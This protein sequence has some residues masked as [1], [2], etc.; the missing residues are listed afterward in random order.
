MNVANLKDIYELSH[1][2]QGLLFHTIY[3]PQ[4]GV[5]FEQFSWTLQGELNVLAFKQAWKQVVDRHPILRTGFFWQ[6]L[7]KP[8]Q[9]VYEDVQ[10][11]W[12]EQDLQEF[13]SQEQ[14]KQL[15]AFLQTDRQR[16]FELSQAPLIRLNLFRLSEDTYQFVW[17][18]HHLLLDGW[19][20]SLVFKEVYAFYAAFCQGQNLYLE[21]PRPYRDYITW[22]QQQDLKQAEAFWRKTLKGF[23]KP[24]ILQVDRA[25]GI[26]PSQDE[27]YDRQ[28]IELST[29]TTAALQSL[30]RQQQLTINTLVQGAWALLLSRYSGESDIIFGSTSSGRPATLPGVESMVGLFVNTLPFRVQILPDALLLPWLLELQ[31]HQIE[32]IQYEY[33]PLV[34]VQ[35]WSQVSRGLPL[36]EIGYVLENYP[37]DAAIALGVDSLKVQSSQSFEKTNETLSLLVVP[38]QAL[39]LELWYD[40]RRFEHEA[41]A[42]M[43]GHLQT[44]LTGIITHPTAR[45]AELPMLTP[46]EQHQ[47]L[48]EFNQNSS[49]EN[50]KSETGQCIHQL[51]EQQAI[52]TPDAIAVVFADL[53]L[54]YAQLLEKVNKLAVY[55]QTL[56]VAPGTLVGICIERS[57][58]MIIA[59]LAV[60]KAGGAYLPLDSAYPQ[61]RLAFMLEDAQVQV[62]LTQEKLLNSLP[63]HSARVLCLDTDWET[64]P[65]LNLVHFETWSSAGILPATTRWEQDAPTTFKNYG[66]QN[67]CGLNQISQPKPSDLAYVIYTSGSTGK[68]KG[69]K[70]QHSSLVNAYLAWEDAYQLR[71]SASCHLQMASFAFDVFAGDL[72]RALCSGGKLVLCPRELLLEPQKLYA[73]MLQEKVDCAEFVPAVLRNLVQYLEQSGQ[74]L[75]FMRLLIC[76]S[77]S[78]YGSEYSKFR[79]FCG[80]QTRLINSFGLTE[81]TIDSSYFETIGD[82]ASDRLVPI[83]RP[84]ANTQF[85]ILDSHLQPVP[86]GVPG[87][88]YIGGAGLAQGYFNRPDLTAQRFIFNPFE[89][90]AGSRLYKTGDLTCWLPDGN[91]EFLGRIDYQEKIRG[92]RVELGEIEATLNQHP[93]VQAVAV[94]AQADAFDQKRLVSYVVQNTQYQGT[95]EQSEKSQWETEQISQWQIVYDSEADSYQRIS[96]NQNP[97]FN[98][99]GWNSSYTDLPIPAEEM[100]IWLNNTV[101]RILSLKPNRVLEIGCGTGLIL[102]RIAPVCTQYQGT[103]FSQATLHYIQ[104]VLEIPEYHLSQV[105][106]SQRMA[107]NFAGLSAATYDTIIINSVIQYFPSIDYLLRAIAGAVELVKPGGAIFVG[108]VRSLPLLEAFHTAVI[109]HSASDSLSTAQVQQQVQKRLAQEEELVIDPAFFLALSQYLPQITN[110]EILPKQGRYNNEL[111]KF[112]YDVILHVGSRVST[113]KNVTWLDWQQQSLTLNALIELLESTQP[114]IL[115][116][117]RIPNARLVTEVKSLELL[118]LE[119]AYT[120]VGEL[121]SVLRAIA[122]NMGVEPEDFWTLSEI[123]PYSVDISWS[124]AHADG[125][126]DVLLQRKQSIS[127]EM[128]DPSPNLSPKRREALIPPSLQGKGGRGVRSA[129]EFKVSKSF[130]EMSILKQLDSPRPWQTYANNPLQGKVARELVPQLRHYLQSKLPEYMVPSAFVLLD[131]LPLTPNGKIDRLALPALETIRADEPAAKDVTARTPIQEMLIGIWTQVLGVN[132]I[133]ISDNFFELGGHSLLATQ[134]ISRVREAFQIELPLRCL[135]ESPTIAS[136][137][138]DIDKEIKTQQGLQTPTFLSVSRDEKLPLSFAQQRLWFLCQLAPDKSIYNDAEAL[139]VTGDL[140]IAALE[141]SINEIVRRHE[142]LRMTFPVILGEPTIAIAPTLTINLPVIDLRGIDE[143]QREVKA[144]Q[145]ATEEAKSPFDLTQS[146]L[147]RTTLLWLDQ[148]EY[149][150]LLSLHHIVSDG[151]SMGVWLEELA[152]LYTAF[153]AGK[154]SPLPQLPIQYV[155]F[156]VW[157]RQWLQGE[158]LQKQLTYWQNQ[159]GQNLPPLQLPIDRSRPAQQSYQAR[160]EN[161]L[162][163]LDLT[164]QLQLLSQEEGVTLFMTL[165][166]AFKTLLYCYS[167]QVDIRVG[168]P[169]ANRNRAEIEKLIGF[170]VNTLVLRTDLSKNPSFCELLRRVREVTL[171]AY[172][173]QDLPFEKIVEQLRPERQ[174]NHLPLFQ[175]WFVLQNAPLGTLELPS[176]TLQ[177]LDIHNGTSEYDLGL[178]LVETPEGI[179]GCFEYSTDLFF[180]DTITRM[181][182]HWQELLKEIVT[183]ADLKIDAIAANFAQAERVHKTVKAQEIEVA[184]IQMLKNIKRQSAHRS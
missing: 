107:D 96:L 28:Q 177:S 88:L 101:E 3:A 178:F 5:Y 106:L 133:G 126:Y 137:S 117:C 184:N 24:T 110:V 59:P 33:S 80:S 44:L 134:V 148:T 93:A 109:L 37:V 157:Q 112:R 89:K 174:Q 136:L 116:L 9:V 48:V 73:L 103:D 1:I 90:T 54:T 97:A 120:T 142:T 176:L 159:L 83:G 169:I 21:Q 123:L 31:N 79:S 34:Q 46:A 60:L 27:D 168:S 32:I 113:P 30:A 81:A 91:V 63:L 61:E 19:S 69:V 151:W 17:S 183:T 102:F 124:A 99:T 111:S 130:P 14:Q 35:G 47:L 118:K 40:T 170:F 92:Y 45:L 175:V 167:R 182:A 84:F 6:D 132:K 160:V 85:Y 127:T 145:I 75:D 57:L 146:P 108:D 179:S 8:Y 165:L 163:P 56:G 152:G 10:L 71:S 66:S 150:L 78:W 139:K 147:L 87:E 131:A 23:S 51:V 82:L 36:F 29:E 105:T 100:Q 141:Q 55:L 4:S 129:R 15:E 95:E 140:D 115:G 2:Q 114:E 7:E 166:A 42:R 68:S 39:R 153:C 50:P 144:L 70:I 119:T 155:D 62:L 125:S 12:E 154:P 98:I 77:D 121:R 172:A 181:V 38:D 86:I 20:E 156:A 16:G 52:R 18:S 26:L 13:S 72:I 162:L 67:G 76:G 11:P 65:I 158:V 25:P 128:H 135:F 149:I 22:L 171:G 164:K 74:R 43:L 64:L 180:A 53:Q 173:H 94:V 143:Q 49:R 104:K 161:F 41:I 122:P 138:G 58:D